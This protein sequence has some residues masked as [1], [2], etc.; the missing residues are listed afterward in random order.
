MFHQVLIFNLSVQTLAA[1]RNGTELG[2]LPLGQ[3]HLK[4]WCV[5]DGLLKQPQ[6]R[7]YSPDIRAFCPKIYIIGGKV[8]SRSKLGA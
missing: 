4:M 5:D 3:V 7:N 1:I 2:C 6:T 8:G